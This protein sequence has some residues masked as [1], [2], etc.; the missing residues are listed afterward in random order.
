MCGHMGAAA[1]RN[2]CWLLVE[3]NTNGVRR[4][5]DPQVG[6]CRGAAVRE[7]TRGMARRCPARLAR[8]ARPGAPHFFLIRSRSPA[9]YRGPELRLLQ[10]AKGVDITVGT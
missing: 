2:N 5:F 6:G 9:A 3:L 4:L 1:A 7:T 8:R 10:T